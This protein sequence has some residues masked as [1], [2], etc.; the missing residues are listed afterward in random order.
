MQHSGRVLIANNNACRATTRD[1]IMR[2]LRQTSVLFCSL[3]FTASVLAA[4]PSRGYQT[5]VRNPGIFAMTGDLLLARP[6]LLGIT[7][8]GTTAFVL[9]L[10]FTTMAGNTGEAAQELI[11]RPGRET[12]VRCLGCTKT[13]YGRR[14]QDAHR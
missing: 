6:L 4:E 1:L 3:L 13:G 7:A 12:F 14:Q 10:P 5:E 11:V 8:V 2:L 9:S